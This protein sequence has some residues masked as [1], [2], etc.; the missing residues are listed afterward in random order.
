MCS[1]N[2]EE[3]TRDFTVRETERLKFI[4]GRG[5]EDKVKDHKDKDKEEEVEE[6]VEGEEVVKKEILP[7]S[8]ILYN[9]YKALEDEVLTKVGMRK[10]ETETSR[11]ASKQAANLKS[12]L[13]P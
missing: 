5:A 3:D 9:K 12:L 4:T 11:R 8:L 2:E 1:A 6:E 13:K 10:T 7:P